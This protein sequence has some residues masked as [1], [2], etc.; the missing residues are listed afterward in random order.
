MLDTEA[1]EALDGID[2]ARGI[3][4]EGVGGGCQNPCLKC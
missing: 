4:R 3:G 1:F 2:A